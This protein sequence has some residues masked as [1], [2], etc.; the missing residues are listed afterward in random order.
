[1]EET[2]YSRTSNTELT[3]SNEPESIRPIYLFVYN[4]NYNKNSQNLLEY[5]LDI[6]IAHC[7]FSD[8]YMLGYTAKRLENITTEKGCAMQVRNRFS[9]SSG[10]TWSSKNSCWA[11]FGGRL[12][13]SNLHR[14][15]RFQGN[16]TRYII[17]QI[18]YF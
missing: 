8:G 1:M 13:M 9:D 14:T 5:G 15:C 6:F 4:Y 11:E 16:L 10:A 3:T 2:K 17:T 12:V 7:V 18:A